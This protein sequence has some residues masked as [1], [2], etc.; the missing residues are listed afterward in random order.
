MPELKFIIV[1]AGAIYEIDATGEAMLRTLS[2]RLD[3][4]NISFLFARVQGKVMA[5]LRRTHFFNP[6][7][8]HR[9]F[10]SREEAL[11]Y[12][13]T[14]LRT[15]DESECPMEDCWARDLTNCVLREQRRMPGEPEV[16]GV[17]A[18]TRADAT[19]ARRG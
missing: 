7:M 10:R 5:A 19:G 3:N 2:E 9:F 15:E 18:T 11:S 12:A 6:E 14:R 16:R 13:W 17:A 4:L 8:E 1:D